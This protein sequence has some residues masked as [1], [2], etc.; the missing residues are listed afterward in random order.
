ML[1]LEQVSLNQ[2]Q[3]IIISGFNLSLQA[4]ERIGLIGPSG[5]GKTSIL[6]TVANLLPTATGV[7]RNQF[8]RIGYVFQ[9]PRLLPWKSALDNVALPLIARGEN[10]KAARAQAKQW[11][12]RLYLPE[13]CFN[14]YPAALSGGMAQRVSLARAFAL[15]PDLLLLDEPFSALDPAL[16]KELIQL[17]DQ[18]LTDLN[19]ALIYVCHHPEELSA[20][21]QRCLILESESQ[22]HQVDLTDANTIPEQL[23]NS[24]AFM[25]QRELLG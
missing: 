10:K 13:Q 5:V 4:G 12:Q 23:I 2:G 7:H 17:C 9:E 19:C 14:Q 15:Q 16:R 6:Q 8:Q 24:E 11:L 1:L 25:A 22:H 3:K 18:L 20:L 21:T